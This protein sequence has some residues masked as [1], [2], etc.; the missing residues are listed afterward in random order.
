M[1]K[2]L[3]LNYFRKGRATN[4][5]S[6]HSVIYRNRGDIFNDL[7][8]F[9]Q[10]YY[11][12]MDSTIAATRE[13]KIKYVFTSI[14]E[15]DEMAEALSNRYPE[16]KEYF[17]LVKKE[18]N[19]NDCDNGYEP[20][21]GN[22][23][24]GSLCPFVGFEVNYKHL[25]NIIDN[26]N[27]VI[28]GGS[29]E[30]DFFYDT[31]EGHKKVCG[32]YFT[33]KYGK[34]RKPIQNGNYYYAFDSYGDKVRM[35]VTNDNNPIPK[36]PELIDLLITKKCSHGCAFCYNNSTKNGAHAT[37]DNISGILGRLYR[38][39][40]FSIGGG[41]ILEHPDLERIFQVI[42]SDK[43][44][45]HIINV[46][47]K[48]EDVDTILNDDKLR[49][50]FDKYVDGIGV[51]VQNS[52]SHIDAWEKLSLAFNGEYK[53]ITIHVIPELLGIDKTKAI[54]KCAMDR[55]GAY[56]ND[57]YGRIKYPKILFLGFKKTG[58]AS[59][60]DVHHFSNDELLELFDGIYS[61]S[62]DTSFANN[63]RAFMEE[64]MD[65][66]SVTYNEGEFSMYIDAVDM[67]AY[68]CSY[69]LSKPYKID[70][71]NW[72]TNDVL[73]AFSS[74]RKDCGFEVYDKSKYKKYYEEE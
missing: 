8:I 48:A 65:Q 57:E 39:T 55:F 11:G 31:I 62:I 49:N 69:D 72:R 21:I 63:Y 51:S 42:K 61:V 19:R 64:E 70:V 17:H 14:F 6:T 35:C 20:Y 3:Y 40:E 50:I 45:N 7:A 41:N 12:R 4:S 26:D 67:K 44:L 5:S 37:T 56:K 66:M 54:F 46:T 28:V 60:M 30:E 71:K 68:R 43:T 53:Y 24:R 47:I 25:C 38:T 18:A 33:P 58:R 1:A 15:W 36:Y 59:D 73:N 10:D 34:S 22:S 74:I 9:E 52:N 16:M 23:Y 2:I 27:I 13:A 32:D 29:D